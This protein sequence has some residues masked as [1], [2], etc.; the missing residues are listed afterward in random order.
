M[1][2][3]ASEITE[4]SNIQI[5]ISI[6][7]NAVGLAVRCYILAEL[8]LYFRALFASSIRFQKQK[9]QMRGFL[10]SNQMSKPIQEKTMGY[11][12]YRYDGKYYEQDLIMDIIG[13]KVSIKERFSLRVIFLMKFRCRKFTYFSLLYFNEKFQF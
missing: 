5:F 6:S 12:D 13:S 2:L 9:H 10:A 4:E 7:L 11:Y 3:F 8:F 1:A